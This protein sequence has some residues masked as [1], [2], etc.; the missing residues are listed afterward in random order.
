M[1]PFDLKEAKAG[2]PVQTREGKSV[3]IL[4]FNRKHDTH[5]VVALVDLDGHT[6]AVIPYTEDGKFQVDKEFPGDIVMAPCPDVGLHVDDFV[7]FGTSYSNPPPGEKDARWF[8]F[9]KRLPANLQCEFNDK[10]K[11]L[12]LF[13]DYEG[14]RFR[15]TGAS[16]M[17]DVWLTPNFNQDVGYTKRIDVRHCSNW[18]L[19]P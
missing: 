12:K 2:K 1:K 17:G 11:D 4:S 9:L 14:S 13:C 19:K 7:D 5:K 3:T 10:I 6:E 16:R 18:G 8:L 15:C